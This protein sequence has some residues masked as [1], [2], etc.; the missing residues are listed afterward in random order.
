M[1]CVTGVFALCASCPGVWALSPGKWRIEGLKKKTGE[2]QK[3]CKQAFI[4]TESTLLG[5]VA[6]LKLED[7]KVVSD[8]D[9]FSL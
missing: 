3:W 6:S 4:G 7:H 2:T 8:P 9:H 1:D 5:R